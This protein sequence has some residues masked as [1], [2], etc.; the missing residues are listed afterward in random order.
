[1]SPLVKGAL[2]AETFESSERKDFWSDVLCRRILLAHHSGGEERFAAPQH[3][4]GS[5]SSYTV[6]QADV[7]LMVEIL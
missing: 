4:C 7:A 6:L 1:M 3:G 5:P 2:S